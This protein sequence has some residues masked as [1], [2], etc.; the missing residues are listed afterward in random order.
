M[1]VFGPMLRQKAEQTSEI[2]QDKATCSFYFSRKTTH[3]FV[4]NPAV[5]KAGWSALF[6]NL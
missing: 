3:C 6:E 5:G 4:K 2:E 1:E